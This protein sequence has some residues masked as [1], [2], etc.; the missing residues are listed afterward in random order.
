MKPLQLTYGGE[1]Y[2]RTE[3]LYSGTVSPEGVDLTYVRTG[4]EDLFWRQGHYGEFDLSEFS[5]GAY[6]STLADDPAGFVAIPVFPSRAFRHSAIY[7]AAPSDLVDASQL[8]G[9]TIGIPEWSQT[10]TL[11]VRGILADHY[12]VDLEKVDWR[13]GGL[14][15]PGRVDKS[16]VAPPTSCSIEP[17][18]ARSTLIEELTA[19]RLDA[20]ISARSPGTALRA[21]AV[22]RLFSNPRQVEADYFA[23]TNIFPIMHVVTMRRELAEAHRWLPVTLWN[24]FEAARALGRRPL[25]DHLYC[26]TSL[27]WEAE[28]ATEESEL[29]GDAF[30]YGIEPNRPTLET[31]IRYGAEQG[32]CDKGLL[33]EDLFF[34]T[35][36]TRARI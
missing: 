16:K 22:R 33:P 30:A 36:R 17:I 8:A 14:E 5:F 7:V 15:Q 11:W 2:D 26:A 18:D 28:Y 20:V 21:G 1:V 12:G 27:A 31:I 23:A 19:G 13:T 34:E 25:L 35:T 32:F 9:A 10:A 29:L 24:A 3:A 6:L 4:I